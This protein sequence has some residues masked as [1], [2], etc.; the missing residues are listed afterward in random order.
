MLGPPAVSDRE[1]G[2]LEVC[3]LWSVEAPERSPRSE[4]AG[5]NQHKAVFA[6]SVAF[7]WQASVALL[8]R[9]IVTGHPPLEATPST[10]GQ[11]G[12]TLTRPKR[13]VLTGKEW[14]WSPDSSFR[15][16]GRR[17]AQDTGSPQPR[18]RQRAIQSL[19]L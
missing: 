9:R 6:R 16:V 11:M 8:G 13:G 3:G 5:A 12:A 15:I 19:K 2:A 18:Q 7:L 17:M 4:A 1:K 10:V 14:L